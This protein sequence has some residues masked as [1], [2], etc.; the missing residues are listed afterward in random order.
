MMI[1]PLVV[2]DEGALEKKEEEE[3]EELRLEKGE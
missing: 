2:I 3:E 1:S